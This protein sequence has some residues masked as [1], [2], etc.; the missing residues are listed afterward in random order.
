MALY[1][2]RPKDVQDE[3]RQKIKEECKVDLVE[4]KSKM[5]LQ[6]YNFISALILL[7]NMVNL[8]F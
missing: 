4:V 6:G 7:K 5:V 8:G 1:K 3:I 2:N